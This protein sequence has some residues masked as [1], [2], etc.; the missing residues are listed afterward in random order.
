M[1]TA[2][3][4]GSKNFSAKIVAAQNA[5]TEADTSISSVWN[6]AVNNS[7]DTFNQAKQAAADFINERFNWSKEKAD[8]AIDFIAQF[9][10]SL[11]GNVT[12]IYDQ[13]DAT[14][15]APLSFYWNMPRDKA[16]EAARDLHNAAQTA[17]NEG[18]YSTFDWLEQYLATMFGG[19]GG[20][21]SAL[22]D[23]MKTA[24]T[25]ATNQVESLMELPG[26]IFQFGE[27]FRRLFDPDPE[28]LKED[29]VRMAQIQRDVSEEITRQTGG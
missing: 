9:V 1:T 24:G 16:D 26:L 12:G 18:Q 20:A 14:L 13:A 27:M 28:M 25:S 11:Q 6:N 17:Y 4:L 21:A 23:A 2:R 15:K 10:P 8:A 22:F 29:M 7:V 3:D 5:T 19:G